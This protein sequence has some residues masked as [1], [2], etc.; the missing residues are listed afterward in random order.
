MRPWFGSDSV[1]SL[2]LEVW[3]VLASVFEDVLK[4]LF[5]LLLVCIYGGMVL[6]VIFSYSVV[7]SRGSLKDLLLECENVRPL[8]L[9]VGKV[10]AS[11][12]G[13][14]LKLLFLLLL[15]CICGGMVLRVVGKLVFEYVIWIHHGPPCVESTSSHGVCSPLHACVP[16]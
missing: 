11:V 5:L 10:P 6:K 12:F 15:V 1:Q 4:L 9:E 14:V 13:D 2:W 7:V 8:W 16:I 3:K